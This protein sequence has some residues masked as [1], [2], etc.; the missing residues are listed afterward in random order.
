MDRDYE[1]MVIIRSDLAQGDLD[2]VFHKISGRIEELG[3]KVVNARIWARERELAYSLRSSTA[4]RQRFFK[5][6]YWLI[7]FN[8]ATDKLSELKETIRLEENI[9]RN[10]II[11]K[12]S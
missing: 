6:C 1:S 9:L 5:A 4:G 8:L 7:N 11:R 10:I 12:D 2:N 3:G